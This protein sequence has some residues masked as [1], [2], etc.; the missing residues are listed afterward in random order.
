MCPFVLG[1]LHS[2]TIMNDCASCT[3]KLPS[4]GRCMTC[5]ECRKSFHLGKS[6]SGIAETT[7][8]A[9]G[10]AKREAWKCKNC[11]SLSADG[12]NTTGGSDSGSATPSADLSVA[13]ELGALREQLQAIKDT[14]GSLLPLRDKVD[15]LLALKPKIDE[16][17]ALKESVTVLDNSVQ[18]LT[19]RV[20]ASE[21][22][23]KNLEEQVTELTATL[24]L[25]SKAISQLRAEL[26]D[27]E[28]YSRLSNLELNGL[29]FTPGE[30]L[31]AVLSDLAQKLEVT[32]F[33][34]K[35][36]VAVH[37]LP[38]R[39][40]KTPTVLIRFASTYIRDTWWAARKKLRPLSED[41][42]SPPLYLNEN[43]TQANKDLYWKARSKGKEADYKFVWT[44]NG[45]I[46]ARKEEGSPRIR[47]ESIAD[48]E[49]LI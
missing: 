15:E 10:P 11:R 22:L 5:A 3:K 34:D 41:T 7:F 38:A 36:V 28:Q 1:P 2:V 48:L 20:T 49:Q 8:Q 14:I 16:V 47:L 27:S 26:N 43:L 32:E 44:R 21:Q 18:N 9:M 30:N 42:L 31:R 40:N 24:S 12:S 45:K 33:D 23:S 19:A 29:P 4:D 25:Q 35:D 13:Q 39:Q 46:F 37:R 17:L 6:C